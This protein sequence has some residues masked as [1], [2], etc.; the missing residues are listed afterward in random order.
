MIRITV[1][2][3]ATGEYVQHWID[4]DPAGLDCFVAVNCPTCGKIHF[5]NRITHKLLGHENERSN[6]AA[7]A[8]IRQPFEITIRSPRQPL[9]DLN[10]PDRD[11]PRWTRK[12]KR[13]SHK[14]LAA[15]LGVWWHVNQRA[16][17]PQQGLVLGSFHLAPQELAQLNVRQST[18]GRRIWLMDDERIAGGRL[19]PKEPSITVWAT[20]QFSSLGHRKLLICSRYIGTERSRE[21][22]P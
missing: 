1:R 10:A 7:V 4:G 12:T 21:L 13:P 2:C 19:A 15:A 3:P 20:I 16:D 11:A 22:A 8:A 17:Q 9:A 5:I 18:T 14:Q 6:L